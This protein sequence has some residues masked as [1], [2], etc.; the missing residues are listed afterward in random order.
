MALDLLV[1]RGL[2]LGDLLTGLP[3]LRALRRAFPGH[4]LVLAAPEAYRELL[5]GEADAWLD[6]R[7]PGPV[8]V[9][10]CDVAVNLHGRGPESVAALRAAGPRLL[11]SHTTGP[12]WNPAAHEVARWC[13]LLGRYGIPADPADL[14]LGAHEGGGP[15]VVHPGAAFPARRWPPER[16]ADVAAALNAEGRP[17]VVT[18]GPG[19]TD[20]ARQ[21]AGGLPVLTPTLTEL[22]GLV[23]RARLVICGDTGVAHLAAA[24]GTPSVVLFGPTPPSLWGPPPGPHRVIWHGRAGDPHG[25]A[26]DPGL[27]EI[28]VTEVLG[29]ARDRLEVSVA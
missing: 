24:Y 20:L 15:I 4:R 22:A 27:L 6:V 18:A 26:P 8:P 2:G 25:R 3:A 17:V 9:T 23:R 14:R 10:G 29:A 19:E 5:G 16:F 12:P 7:G 21:V 13:D 11:I 1:L 28:T